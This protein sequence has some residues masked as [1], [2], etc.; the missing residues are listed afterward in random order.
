VKLLSCQDAVVRCAYCNLRMKPNTLLW[1]EIHVYLKV[2]CEYCGKLWL[3]EVFACYAGLW[4]TALE[5]KLQECFDNVLLAKWLGQSFLE[6]L[7]QPMPGMYLLCIKKT[8]TVIL[9]SLLKR[10]GHFHIHALLKLINL[11][12][13]KSLR[14]FVILFYRS[15]LVL[16]QAA[17]VWRGG[18]VVKALLL[19]WLELDKISKEQFDR[20]KSFSGEQHSV[21][22][23]LESVTGK[24][25]K[26]RFEVLLGGE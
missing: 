10:L 16:A 26:F 17:E 3:K 23:G 11:V 25:S 13:E 7:V 2:H 6:V 9:P 14:C 12:I 18:G 21:S 22:I 24:R 19:C 1:Q 15:W 4:A 5:L 8:E 20:L